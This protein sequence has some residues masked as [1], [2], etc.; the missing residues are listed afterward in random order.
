VITVLS[1]KAFLN[2]V[3]PADYAVISISSTPSERVHITHPNKLQLVFGDF[4]RDE[5]IK[6]T[7][8]YSSRSDREFFLFNDCHARQIIK[9]AD[10]NKTRSFI[11]HCDAGISRSGAVGLFLTRYL[12]LDEAEFKQHNCILPNMYIYDV[13]A[14]KS[15]LADNYANF[16]GLSGRQ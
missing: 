7:T 14:K 15:G 6:L 2:T 12:G 3:I 10:T 9:F 4:S 11:V 13:L 16:W 1:R 8:T 5:F